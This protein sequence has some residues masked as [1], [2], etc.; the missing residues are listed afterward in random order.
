L[1]ERRIKQS[2]VEEVNGKGK[3]KGE[4][5]FRLTTGYESPKAE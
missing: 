1:A 2:D 5:K 3:G 4:G